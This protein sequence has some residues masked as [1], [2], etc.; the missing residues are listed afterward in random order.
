MEKEGGILS[1]F[2]DLLNKNNKKFV[3]FSNFFN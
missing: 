3:V 1:I 2:I